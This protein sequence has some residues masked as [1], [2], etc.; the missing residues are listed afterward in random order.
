MEDNYQYYTEIILKKQNYINSFKSLSLALKIKYNKTLEETIGILFLIP[1]IF[2]L[3]FFQLIK[4]LPNVNV[5]NENKFKE[6][7]ILMR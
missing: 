1:Q 4:K 7:Y 6:K 2:L 5:P 3:D